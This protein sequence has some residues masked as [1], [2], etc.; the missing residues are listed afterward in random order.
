MLLLGVGVIYLRRRSRARTAQLMRQIKRE[1]TRAD[2][3]ANFVI[4]I[5]LSMANETN[6]DSL[7]EKILLEAKTLSLADGGTLYLVTPENTLRFVIIVNN[8]LHLAMGGTTKQEVTLAPLALYDAATGE[9]NRHN[10]ATSCAL[11]GEAIAVADAYTE[12]GYDFSGAKAFDQRMNYRTMSVL[13]VPLRDVQR[14]VIGVLQLIN[15]KSPETGMTEPFSA[16]ARQMMELLSLLAA[17]ALG[18]YMKI[19]ILTDQIAT[20]QIQIDEA[21]KERQVT[22]IT[23]SDYFKDLQSRARSMRAKIKGEA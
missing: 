6:L 1:K 18:S 2:K 15:A 14:K 4:P 19:K 9:P 3:L 17:A 22:E 5:G 7:L 21:K 13:C 8:S 20:L 12:V 11:S 23:G 10:I 16:H